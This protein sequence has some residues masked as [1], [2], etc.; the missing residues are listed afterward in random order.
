VAVS[1]NW[2]LAINVKQPLHIRV[3]ICRVV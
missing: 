3:S 1:R 2:L